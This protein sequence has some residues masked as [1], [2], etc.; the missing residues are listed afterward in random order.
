MKAAVSMDIQYIKQ[1][2][3]LTY[4]GMNLLEEV[5]NNAALDD[6][7]DVVITSA[8][9][10]QILRYNGTSW[11]N[12]ASGTP[13]LLATRTASA[14]ATLDFTEFNNAVYRRYEFELENVLPATDDV[15]LFLRTST[16]GGTSYSNTAGDYY[17]SLTGMN[18]TAATS[19][20]VASAGGI[21]LTSNTAGERM[22]NAAG[23]Y[24]ASGIVRIFN[25][26]N[27]SSATDVQ[28][29]VS[30]YNTATAY[31]QYVG[32]GVRAAAAD[33][34]AVRFLMTIGN[35]ASGTIRMYGIV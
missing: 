15:S 22:G 21:V 19:S 7:G 8:T 32:A 33:V 17:W 26:G 20:A 1:D 13:I 23:E 2:G 31:S 5:I 34:D 10:G 6:L 9:T 12:V 4:E 25:A 29:H 30:Y 14:S 16:N 18:G 28:S 35:I 3:S 11:V 27:A 24:G